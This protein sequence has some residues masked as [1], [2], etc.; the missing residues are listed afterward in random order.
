MK[1]QVC[2]V[3]HT[4]ALKYIFKVLFITCPKLFMHVMACGIYYI[5][6]YYTLVLMQHI[7][8][9]IWKS[10]HS[11]GGCKVDSFF[12]P[13]EV[14]QTSTGSLWEFK[15]PPR[16]GSVALRQLNP[17]HKK[18]PYN[19]GFCISVNTAKFYFSLTKCF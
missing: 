1:K 10:R 18:R 3:L 4:Y 9:T 14:N 11:L 16:S 6:I 13:S 5:H 19:L 7:L 2:G 15:L 12:H 17:I 8:K